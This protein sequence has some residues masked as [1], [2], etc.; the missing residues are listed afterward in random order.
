MTADLGL[1]LAAVGRPGYINLGR[2][3]DLPADRSADVMRARAFD[4]LDAAYDVGIRYIDAARSY[5]RA[6]EFLAAW[7]DARAVDRVF[8][9]SKWG[10]EYTANWRVDA[11]VHEIKEHTAA[12]LDKQYAESRALLG[13][14]LRLYQVHSATLDSG[15]LANTA[16]HNRLAELKRDGVEIGI[17]VS[18][19]QQ[20]ETVLRALDVH[21]NGAQLFSSVQATWNVLETSV[22]PALAAAHAAG[23]RVIVKEALA[24]GRLSPRGDASP[25]LEPVAAHHGVTVDAIAIAAAAQQPWVSVVLSGAATPEQVRANSNALAI[26]GN[27]EVPDA[28]ERPETYWATRA[29][30]PWS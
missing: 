11:D 25:L 17:T 27:V 13:D 2:S 9:A 30:L 8:V 5:G 23:W 4:V 3:L 19:P 7:L 22:V 15:V 21:V 14:R 18:G 16:V 10:Y 24:N 29:A 6:E 28:A 26:R 1:G 12:M 20:G